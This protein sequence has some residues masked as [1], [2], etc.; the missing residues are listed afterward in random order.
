MVEIYC[1]LIIAKR[2]QFDKVPDDFITQ[3]EARL[4]ELGYDKNGEPITQED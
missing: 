2:R 4:A 1:R 3:V